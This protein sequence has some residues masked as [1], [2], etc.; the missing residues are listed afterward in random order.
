[1]S[2]PALFPVVILNDDV[3]TFEQLIQTIRYVFGLTDAEAEAIANKVH[4]EGRATLGSYI[5]EIAET[6]VSEIEY[7]NELNNLSINVFIDDG[8]TIDPVLQQ[9]LRDLV[10][11]KNDTPPDII[12]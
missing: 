9:K 5:E 7:I 4:N 8:Q 10:K 12:E 3:T 1:M 6:K 2:S 11:P